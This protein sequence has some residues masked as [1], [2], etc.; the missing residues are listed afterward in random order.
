MKQTWV[1]KEI[2]KLTFLSWSYLRPLAGFT[3]FLMILDTY[4]RVSGPLVSSLTKFFF[5][6]SFAI[7]LKLIK[8][9]LHKKSKKCISPVTCLFLLVTYRIMLVTYRIRNSHTVSWIKR[10]MALDV[11]LAVFNSFFF[12]NSDFW[13]FEIWI[14]F[15][16]LHGP[17]I[18]FLATWRPNFP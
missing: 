6:F 13:V 9:T 3:S 17:L 18:F 7:K 10:P 8:T 1:L 2:E 14:L 15:N 5:I 12:L 4:C 11:L 16:W